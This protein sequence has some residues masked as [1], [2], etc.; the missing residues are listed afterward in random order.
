MGLMGK[1]ATWPS[2][3]P[4]ASSRAKDRRRL[5]SQPLIIHIVSEASC[6]QTSNTPQPQDNQPHVVRHKRH[7]TPHLSSLPSPSRLWSSSHQTR[8]LKPEVF[9]NN[10]QSM[11]RRKI[12][13]GMD[14]PGSSSTLSCTTRSRRVQG[15]PSCRL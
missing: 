5:Q 10:Q 2:S 14:D 6:S 8:Y 15:R 12:A 4:V 7:L 9:S 3:K 1:A 13:N 11:H